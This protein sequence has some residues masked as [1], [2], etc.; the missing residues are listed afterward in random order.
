MYPVFKYLVGSIQVDCSC[1]L[2]MMGV[3]TKAQ[4]QAQTTLS[5]GLSSC[6]YY[7]VQ[8]L[9]PE[10]HGKKDGWEHDSHGDFVGCQKKK[11]S[12]G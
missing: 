4:A 7:H 9:K 2:V 5:N 1:V 8:Q 11:G 10:P 12:V 6:N 3:C